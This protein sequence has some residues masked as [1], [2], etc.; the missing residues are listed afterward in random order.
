VAGC[1]DCFIMLYLAICLLIAFRFTHVFPV[2]VVALA[3]YGA[4]VRR[5]S[6]TNIKSVVSLLEFNLSLVIAFVILLVWFSY[7]YRDEL[8]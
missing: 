3:V 7:V 4:Y 2:F 1:E 5:V 8:G 6:Q